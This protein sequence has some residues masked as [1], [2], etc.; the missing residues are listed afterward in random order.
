MLGKQRVEEVTSQKFSMALRQRQLEALSLAPKLGPNAKCHRFEAWEEREKNR[1][2]RTPNF[3]KHGLSLIEER[4]QN[5]SLVTVH[6][7]RR[8]PPSVSPF[9]YW[10]HRVVCSPQHHRAIRFGGVAS[11]RRHPSISPC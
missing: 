11:C 6:L 8:S 9:S 7:W 4:K 10:L 5:P 1:E 2:S 3:P